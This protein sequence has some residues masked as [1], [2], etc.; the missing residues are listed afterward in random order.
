MCIVYSPFLEI[1]KIVVPN[2]REFG[3]LIATK[4]TA[5]IMTRVVGRL[6]EQYRLVALSKRFGVVKALTWVFYY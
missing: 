2:D 3:L 1:Q 5:T 4:D 6:L